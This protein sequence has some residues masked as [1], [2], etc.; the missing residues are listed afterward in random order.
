M[1]TGISCPLCTFRRYHLKTVCNYRLKMVFLK[2]N[3]WEI[4]LEIPWVDE[5]ENR[6]MSLQ[7]QQYIKESSAVDWVTDKS[8]RHLET[9]NSWH[10]RRAE[11]NN[12]LFACV[13]PS[14]CWAAHHLPIRGTLS[15]PAAR[16]HS[17]LRPPP[18][19]LTTVLVIGDISVRPS[20]YFSRE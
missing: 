19:P 2:L 14:F 10:L 15:R 17:L 18:P 8:R 4:V 5:N 20:F 7:V 11:M 9:L 12:Q 16:P 1:H 3:V 13:R 6:T